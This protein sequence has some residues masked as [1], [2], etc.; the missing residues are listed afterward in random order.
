MSIKSLDDVC[1]LPPELFVGSCQCAWGI[2]GVRGCWMS[3]CHGGIYK[4]LGKKAFKM[5]YMREGL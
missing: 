5:I 1:G 2:D 3:R 4:L